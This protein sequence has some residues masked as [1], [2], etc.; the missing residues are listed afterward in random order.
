MKPET[1]KI[2][3]LSLHICS[4]IEEGITNITSPEKVDGQTQHNE[5]LKG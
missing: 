2:W 4:R 5:E 1:L 3:G